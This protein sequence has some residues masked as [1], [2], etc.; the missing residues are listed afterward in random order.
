MENGPFENVFLLK[1][2]IPE[3]TSMFVAF[4]CEAVYP[5]GWTTGGSNDTGAMAVLVDRYQV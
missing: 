2:G 4:P 3:G 1:M 5:H